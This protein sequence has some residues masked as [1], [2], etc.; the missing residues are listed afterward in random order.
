MEKQKEILLIDF[1]NF[2]DYPIGG[3]LTFAKNLMSSFNNELKLIGITTA[4]N[5]PVG[6]WFKKE[7]GGVVYDFLAL[8]KYNKSKTKHIIPDRLSSFFL[9]KFYKKEILKKNTLNVFIQ[10]PEILVAVK[11]FKFKNICYRFAGI[12]NPLKLS[13]YW[14]ARYFAN[15]FDKITFSSFK[16]VNLV[17]ASSDD[18]AINEM[19]IRSNGSIDSKSVFKFPTRIN[20]D[21]FKPLDKSIA[22]KILDIK[23]SLMIISTTGRLSAGKGWKFMIDC[24]A[25]FIKTYPNSFFYFIGDG[26]DFEKIKNYILSKGLDTK[27]KLTGRKTSDEISLYL[28]A[29]DLYI[30]GSSKEGWSTTLVEACACGVPICTTNFS[31]AKEI[32]TEGVNG[33]VIEKND[34]CCFSNKMRDA[35]ILGQ[36]NIS[37]PESKKY[38]MSELKTDLLNLWKLL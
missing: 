20:T 24:F 1:C 25:E 29:S 9:I 30:M 31:S 13:K 19:I 33:Y 7:I 27:I 15:Y 26:E 37:I 23:D 38:A 34:V 16:D 6:K 17:L 14:Y 21:I 8:T 18:V 32:V 11:D 5:D 36:K 10:R 22:R 12:E 28:N 4:K 2:E 35:L 3:Q